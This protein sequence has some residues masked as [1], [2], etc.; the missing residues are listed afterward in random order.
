MNRNSNHSYKNAP[1]LGAFLYTEIKYI[2]FFEVF[3]H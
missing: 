3:I 1:S 2:I